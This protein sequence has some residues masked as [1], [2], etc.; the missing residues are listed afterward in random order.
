MA[1]RQPPAPPFDN[2]LSSDDDAGK[3]GG[4]HTGG[5]EEIMVN[6][7]TIVSESLGVAGLDA[8]TGVDPPPPITIEQT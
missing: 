6:T 7:T 3:R 1:T 2:R 8:A 5:P 4:Q